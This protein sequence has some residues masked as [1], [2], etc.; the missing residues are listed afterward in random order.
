L[1]KCQRIGDR[2]G[3]AARR[4]SP[5]RKALHWLRTHPPH[6]WLVSEHASPADFPTAPPRP[7]AAQSDDLTEVLAET[8]RLFA[9]AVADRRSAFRTPTVATVGSDGAPSARTMVLRRFDPTTRRLTV[10][11]DQRARKITDIGRTPRVAVHVY[12]ARAAL[13]VRFSAMAWVHAGDAMARAAWLAGAPASHAVYAVTPAPGTEVPAPLPP[14]TYQD[15]GFGNFAVLALTFDMLEW[16]S[17]HHGGH[18]RARFAWA[19]DG[20]LNAAWL[21]P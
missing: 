13:Q 7:L 17:L 6:L 1:Q 12:D 8:F 4:R 3:D 14:P 19:A 11:S 2:Q 10:H 5:I 18:R 16:L 21:V 20:S 9:R 15:E